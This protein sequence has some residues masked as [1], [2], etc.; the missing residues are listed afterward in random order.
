[1]K[2]DYEVEGYWDNVAKNIA[3]RKDLRVIAGEDDPF[4]RHKRQLFL[5]LFEQLD[6]AGKTVL[7]IGS[8]PGGNL[9]QAHD[10]GAKSV[11]GVDVSQHMVSL[12]RENL[13]G[14]N[15]EVIKINGRD[16]P[17]AD[18]T[19]DL[20]FTSTVLQH[21]VDETA[22]IALVNEIA[23]VAAAK[24]VLFERIEKRIKGNATT[25]GRP[26]AYYQQLLARHGFQLNKT[27]FL[28]IQASY[29][30]CGAIRKLLNSPRHQEG[31]PFTRISLG[32]QK[33]A[34]PVTTVLDRM[35]PSTRD[36]AMIEFQ[37]RE[38]Q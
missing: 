27:E 18:R 8:G 3:A 38:T 34:M 23:R 30:V 16:L 24:I 19:F 5:R 31:E 7:E 32:A 29:Y 10:K 14:R 22:L 28:P 1:M 35:I 13:Q 33:L 17:F 26:V 36:V 25:T 15:I 6:F 12:A 20:V 21:N 11:T 4:Y 37:R 9:L 2:I